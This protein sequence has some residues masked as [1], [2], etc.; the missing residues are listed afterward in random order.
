MTKKRTAGISAPTLSELCGEIEAIL[1][2][3]QEEH[4]ERD[5]DLTED[6]IGEVENE[7]MDACG[8]ARTQV[9]RSKVTLRR[10]R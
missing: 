5:P 3:R 2:N 7:L 8:F 10:Y 6:L 9:I 4:G 1:R